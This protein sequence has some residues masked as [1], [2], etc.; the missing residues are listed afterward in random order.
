MGRP[1]P[2]PLSPNP[3]K[4][5]RSPSQPGRWVGESAEH[6]VGK[7]GCHWGAPSAAGPYQSRMFCRQNPL[8]TQIRSE[9]VLHSP[10]RPRLPAQDPEG[11]GTRTGGCRV[12]VGTRTLPFVSLSRATSRNP[13]PS[14]S[15]AAS[16]GQAPPPGSFSKS[17]PDLPVV[18][19]VTEVVL[20]GRGLPACKQACKHLS[21]NRLGV[22]GWK[23]GRRSLEGRKWPGRQHS[24]ETSAGLREEAGPAREAS[25]RE[26]RN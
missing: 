7:R 3:G 15:Q 24:L 5:E 16:E 21:G 12:G 8:G 2:Q 22:G 13:T 20:W 11:E 26:G 19:A 9:R 1:F 18:R 10:G 4:A 14:A 17:R 25:H 23:W 6:R